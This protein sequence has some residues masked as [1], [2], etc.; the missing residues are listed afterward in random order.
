LTGT[1]KLSITR[2][3]LEG[4]KR[5]LEAN[6][7]P[8]I[9]ALVKHCEYGGLHQD[10]IEQAVTELLQEEYDAIF[11]SGVK[12]SMG[13]LQA[14]KERPGADLTKIEVTGVANSKA[15]SLVAPPLTAARQPASEL[16]DR[17]AEIS[18]QQ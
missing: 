17:A 13:Y 14:M 4:Y 7:L 16:G 18:V 8:Y 12:L 5:G 9:P 1:K 6:G 10:E 3:R 15:D 11:I 2:E